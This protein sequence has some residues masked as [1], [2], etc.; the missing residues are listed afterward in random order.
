MWYLKTRLGVFWVIPLKD[1]KDKSEKYVLGVNDEK[2][3]FYTDVEQAAKDVHDQTTGFMKWDMESMVKA[4]LHINEWVEGE[5][6]DWGSS[7]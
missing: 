7:H 4:P 6:K 1:K 5:P 2:L 3:A